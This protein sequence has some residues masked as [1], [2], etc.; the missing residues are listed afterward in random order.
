MLCPVEGSLGVATSGSIW[1]EVGCR[2]I[3]CS[4]ISV[5][6]LVQTFRRGGYVHTCPVPPGLPQPRGQAS[7]VPASR[8][9]SRR[10][11]LAP[12]QLGEGFPQR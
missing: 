11:L 5:Q 7:A 4:R 2:Q 6:M 8:G 12:L 9:R 3:L 1:G 10:T